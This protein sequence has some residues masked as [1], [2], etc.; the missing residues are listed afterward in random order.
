MKNT[1]WRKVGLTGIILVHGKK[2]LQNMKKPII[3]LTSDF[4]VQSQGVGNMEGVIFSIYSDAHVIHLSHGI[5]DF[6]IRVGAKTLES[7]Y[8]LPVGFHVCVVDPGVGS[9]RKPIIIKV[10]RGD[11]LIG[12]DNGVL[13]PAAGFLGGFEKAVQITNPK[14]M[15][16]PVSPI[17]HGRHIFAPAAAYLAKGV[18]IDEFGPSLSLDKLVPAPYPEAF[19]KDG[20][21]EAEVINVNKFG[22]LNLNILHKTWDEFNIRLGEEV[23][24]G[25]AD[26]KMNKF[27]PS[28]MKMPF[29]ETFSQVDSAKPLIIKDDYGRI[30][31]AINLGNFAKTYKIK[32]GDRCTIEKT[33]VN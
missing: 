23:I 25:F 10:K 6:D 3:S 13:I 20:L 1:I 28:E 4:G 29:L 22:S 24:L 33:G 18:S 26:Q 27:S 15:I 8:Y 7:V 5:A 11:C 9:L 17:F 12:P 14:L 31:V 2:D 32:T 30:E 16:Q 19:I 21:L